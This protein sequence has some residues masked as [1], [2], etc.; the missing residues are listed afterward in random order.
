MAPLPL[1]IDDEFMK[2]PLFPTH[3]FR[4]PGARWL[5]GVVILLCWAWGP[6]CGMEFSLTRQN[7]YIPDQ[8]D[9]QVLLMRGEIRP[10][11]YDR[12]LQFARRNGY[13]LPL[14]DVILSSPGGDIEEA[15]K[16]GRLVKQLYIT[17]N[18]GAETGYCAS[19]CF[20]IFASAVERDTAPGFVGIHRPYLSRETLRSLSPHAAEAAETAALRDAEQYLRELRVPRNLVDIMFEQASTE[21][22]WLSDDEFMHQLGRRPAWYEEFLIARCGFDKAAEERYFLDPSH[23]EPLAQIKAPVYCGQNLTLNEAKAAYAQIDSDS[24]QREWAT[25]RQGQAGAQR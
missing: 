19:A 12:L 3:V 17:V 14:S 21:I 1:I 15:L 18:V 2:S 16:I 9:R 20:I 23:Q 10:G 7:P 25:M 22:Y 11:D 5:G 13:Y 4:W 24:L 8:L 6:A